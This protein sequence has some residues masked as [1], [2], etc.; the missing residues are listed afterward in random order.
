VHLKNIDVRTC[1]EDPSVAQPLFPHLRRM[2]LKIEASSEAWSLALAL[3]YLC[4]CTLF[5]GC[6]ALSPVGVVIGMTRRC[7]Y[8]SLNT[9][10]SWNQLDDGRGLLASMKTKFVQ[11]FF[12][13]LQIFLEN[14]L[15]SLFASSWLLLLL[16]LFVDCLEALASLFIRACVSSTS[17]LLFFAYV[18]HPGTGTDPADP[19]TGTGMCLPEERGSAR[20]PRRYT[21]CSYHAFQVAI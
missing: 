18:T 19:H 11:L 20:V 13:S 10:R 12:K 16:L 7:S 1:V 5:V 6:A 2:T 14:G 9:T 21:S 17:P 15:L 3:K 8:F 4:S